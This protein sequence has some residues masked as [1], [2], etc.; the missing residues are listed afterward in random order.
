VRE[1]AVHAAVGIGSNSLDKLAER[2]RPA[3]GAWWLVV[4]DNYRIA[5]FGAYHDVTGERP[6]AIRGQFGEQDV[7]ARIALSPGTSLL[8]GHLLGG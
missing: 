8:S 1:A 5:G 2:C 6:A 3:K 7:R 4:Y